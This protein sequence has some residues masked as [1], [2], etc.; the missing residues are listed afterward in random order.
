MKDASKWTSNQIDQM[1]TL[2]RMR[3]KTTKAWQLKEAL[4]E[5][6]RSAYSRKEAEPLLDHRYSWARRCRV[7]QMKEF[8]LTIKRHWDG[9]LNS[10]DSKLTNGSVEEINSLIQAANARARGYSTA[11]NLILMTY[12]IAGK[13]SH[14]PSSPFKPTTTSCGQVTG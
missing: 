8:A 11:E 3:L 12:L 2:S 1:H 6:F 4:R 5:I 10:F 13:L 14:L 9:I 7:P